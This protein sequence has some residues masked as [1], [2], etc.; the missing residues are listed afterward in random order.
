MT[1]APD[2]ALL[3]E[4]RPAILIKNG[5]GRG[6]R[7]EP[8]PLLYLGLCCC[9]GAGCGAAVCAASLSDAASDS[10]ASVAAV[11]VVVTARFV[12]GGVR[13][14]AGCIQLPMLGR[15]LLCRPVGNK[16]MYLLLALRAWLAARKDKTGP[17]AQ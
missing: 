8:V 1:I 16:G 17:S 13:N 3:S 2:A 10:S 4:V 11:T 6:R 9:C 12:T 15:A 7:T 5:F 14:K